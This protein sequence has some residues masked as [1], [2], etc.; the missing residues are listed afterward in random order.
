MFKSAAQEISQWA[1]QCRQ[2]ARDARTGEQRSNLLTLERI[3]NEAA[4]D[5]DDDLPIVPPP[6]PF[7]STKS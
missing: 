6:G 3:L 2:W 4:L 1:D 7:I 5:A